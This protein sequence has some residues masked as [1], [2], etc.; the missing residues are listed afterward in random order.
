[1]VCAGGAENEDACNGDS[2]GPLVGDDGILLGVVSWGIGCGS[3]GLPGV[4]ARVGVA[5]SF[6]NENLG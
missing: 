1:M 6:I 4:Y 3:P 2:G 5:V